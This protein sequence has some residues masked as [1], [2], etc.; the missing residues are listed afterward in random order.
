MPRRTLLTALLIALLSLFLTER[1]LHPF[2]SLVAAVTNPV[3]GP[4]TELT[5]SLRAISTTVRDIRTLRDRVTSL[6]VEAET[7]K[8]NLAEL[9]ALR[10][11]NDLLRGALKFSEDHRDQSLMPARVIRRSPTRFFQ[12][13]TIDRGEAD[14]V[15]DRSPVVANGF[16]IGQVVERFPHQA[17][18]RL[19]TASDSLV[20][21]VFSESRAQGL[22]RGG[23]SGLV[24]T[25]VPAD[26]AIPS[27]ETVVTS[28]IGDGIPAGIPVGVAGESAVQPSSV[29]QRITVRS[30][31]VATKLELVF[32][33]MAVEHQP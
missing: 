14:G 24:V 32:V 10:Q 25:D 31:L 8:A 1:T 23:L 21:V 28:G 11:E 17:T 29:L 12:S 20:G 3:A 6:T 15:Q 2:R 13:V 33:T 4:L 22:L 16:L 27:G 19:I 9:D 5:Q 18:V 7:L 26:V 30:S